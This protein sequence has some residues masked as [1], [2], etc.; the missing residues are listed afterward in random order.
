MALPPEAAHHALRVLR[1]GP[2][3][4][5]CVFDGAGNVAPALVEE[6][7]RD[8]MVVRL[9]APTSPP[10]ESPLDLCLAQGISARDRMDYTIVKAVEL[11][12]ATIQPLAARR[13]VVRLDEDRAGR[14]NAHW[15]GLAI[16]AC[17]QCGRNRVPDILPVRGLADW[18]QALPAP[19]GLPRLLLQPGGAQRLRDLAP[20]AGAVLLAGPEGGL[21]PEEQAAAIAAGFMAVGLG[22]RILRTETAGPAAIA[23]LQALWG[24]L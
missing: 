21:A 13:S 4:G 3:D 14:R 18:L 15:Q 6:T 17:E 24:D 7:G 9:G 20:A 22:P 12:V 11:G 8:R 1:L 2:G 19:A 23:A 5:L 16:S 10:R